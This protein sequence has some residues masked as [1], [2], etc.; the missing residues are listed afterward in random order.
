MTG[1]ADTLD[2]RL[3]GDFGGRVFFGDTLPERREA[4]AA[5]HL[6]HERTGMYL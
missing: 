3:Q 2:D 4:A 1:L 6:A 5:E